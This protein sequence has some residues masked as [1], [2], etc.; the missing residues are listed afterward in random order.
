MLPIKD[1]NLS[2]TNLVLY[3][4]LCA[5]IWIYPKKKSLRLVELET[6]PCH[7]HWKVGKGY[8]RNNWDITTL[9][10]IHVTIYIL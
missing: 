8:I 6:S 3:P 4:K 5:W 1:I 9:L 10:Q 7:P 2:L